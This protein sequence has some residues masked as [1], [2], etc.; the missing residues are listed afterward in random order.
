MSAKLLNSW[1]QRRVW[2]ISIFSRV[3]IGRDG[4]NSRPILGIDYLNMPLFRKTDVQPISWLLVT[5]DSEVL[6]P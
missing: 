6:K 2:E 3:F 1:E 4:N 5:R